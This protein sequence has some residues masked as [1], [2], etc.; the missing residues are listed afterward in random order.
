MNFLHEYTEAY[1]L[2]LRYINDV[3]SEP[4]V[5]FDISFEQ[6][7][8]LTKIQENPKLTMSDFVERRRLSRAAIS[9]ML[10][11]LEKKTLMIRKACRADKRRKYLKITAEGARIQQIIEARVNERF[12]D[13]MNEFGEEK[14]LLIL[15]LI[16]EFEQ[17]FV[18]KTR[19]R[20]LEND[21]D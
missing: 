8:I 21:A 15:D 11:D 10:T 1:L 18:S 5:D 3:V 16:R 13:W 6:Y 17:K 14:A 2:T 4:A 19:E 20:I 7:L 9:L 12:T